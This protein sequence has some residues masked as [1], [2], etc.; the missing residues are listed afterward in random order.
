MEA[1]KEYVRY[2][3]A[4]L[5]PE[6]RAKDLLARMTQEEKQFQATGSMIMGAPEKMKDLVKKGIG[7][8]WY[9]SAANA[10]E[11]VSEITEKIIRWSVEESRLG[12]P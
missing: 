11:D 10:A 12:I 9:D 8:I 7:S 6:E 5:S 1:T 4:S 2:K 3:D